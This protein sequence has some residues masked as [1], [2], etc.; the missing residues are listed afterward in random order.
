MSSDVSLSVPLFGEQ[1]QHP[2]GYDSIWRDYQRTFRNEKD[3]FLTASEKKQF[4]SF[5]QTLFPAH[6]D[7]SSGNGERVQLIVPQQVVSLSS[8]YVSINP[9]VVTELRE[10]SVVRYTRFR[11]HPLSFAEGSPSSPY[12]P[13]IDAVFALFFES[14]QATSVLDPPNLF[15]DRK[16]HE[17]LS[18]PVGT[19]NAILIRD[20]YEGRRTEFDR[21]LPEPAPSAPNGT[22]GLE[23]S[24]HP[25]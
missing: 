2:L 10:S 9:E 25:I 20:F 21:F 22:V 17:L 12:I 13:F 19:L 8:P 18:S 5:F 3:H 11:L 15:F 14:R 16:N 6:G 7:L 24:L 23:V 1:I 4:E